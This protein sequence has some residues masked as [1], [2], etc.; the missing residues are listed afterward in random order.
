MDIMKDEAIK[1]G[2]EY[3][4]R[5][6]RHIIKVEEEARSGDAV[7]EDMIEGTLQQIE[8]E[9]EEAGTGNTLYY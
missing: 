6:C 3:W 5:C 1:C 8:D 2:K 9:G 4:K 7:L